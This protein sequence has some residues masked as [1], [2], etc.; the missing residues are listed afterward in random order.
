MSW[1]KSPPVD[2]KPFQAQVRRTFKSGQARIN[3]KNTGNPSRVMHRI[4]HYLPSS[5]APY[6]LKKLY[7]F[8]HIVTYTSR[9][10][11]SR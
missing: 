4:R 5:C 6:Y 9:P 10:I 3:L 1:L 2:G 7:L 11:T 8:F